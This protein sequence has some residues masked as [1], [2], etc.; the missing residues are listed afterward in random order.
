MEVRKIVIATDGSA[1]SA[2]A[3][4]FGL[5]LALDRG[6]EAVVLNVVGTHE[7]DKLFTPDRLE[8]PT[9]EELAAVSPALA[10]GALFAAGHG[11]TATLELVVADGTQETAD[12]ILGVA[13]GRDADLIVMG[14]RGQGPLA[15]AV[16]GSVS[17]AV[18]R[19][20]T[21]TVVVVREPGA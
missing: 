6:A 5:E 11:I 15:T 12:A 8:P 3:L 14:T 19:A 4:D 21:T 16:I 17:N 1:S 13:A 10:Q 7:V 18:L 9:Q 20:A 2:A